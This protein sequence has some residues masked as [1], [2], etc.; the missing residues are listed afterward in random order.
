M[1]LLSHCVA[2]FNIK[3]Q[4]FSTTKN[5]RVVSNG[6]SSKTTKARSRVEC[7]VL[8][9]SA[10]NCCSS[11][12]DTNKKVCNLYLTCHHLTEYAEGSAIMTKNLEPVP[13]WFLR[14][15]LSFDWYADFNIG[16]CGD[17]GGSNKSFANVN[18]WTSYYKDDTDSRIGG[19]QMRWVLICVDQC[20]QGVEN[21]LCATVNNVTDFYRDD[22]DSTSKGCQMQWKLSVQD[23]APEWI[24]N[25]E[26]CYEWYTDDNQGQ[27]GGVTNGTS[28]AIVNSFTAPYIDHTTGSGGGCYM[29][30]KILIES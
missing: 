13:D 11:S 25:V 9:T 18:E 26:L 20:G 4:T 7:S 28:C 10:D 30:W 15:K 8:C 16:Q 23:D 21:D 22:T 6:L 19:C 3:S 2:S 29:R 1:A 27:C 12:Y 24:Q 5:T 17:G 14:T